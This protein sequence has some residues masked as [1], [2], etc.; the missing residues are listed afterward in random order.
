MDEVL[1]VAADG[2]LHVQETGV[3]LGMEQRQIIPTV[4]KDHRV[5]D[6]RLRTGRDHRHFAHR[7][8]KD[9]VARVGG[10]MFAIG[11]I[12]ETAGTPPG[13]QRGIAVD[14]P[15][16]LRRVGFSWDR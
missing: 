9:R 4:G 8:V 16:R 1:A 6:L 14:L 2:Q 15:G 5:V 13:D 12:G 7:R 3:V 10:P 11:A